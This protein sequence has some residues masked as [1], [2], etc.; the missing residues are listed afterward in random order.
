MKSKK[1][2]IAGGG[3]AG[4]RVAQDLVSAGF[5][6]VTLVDRK[7]YFEVTYATLR[8]LIEPETLGQRARMKFADFITAH[9]LQG[10]VSRL[11][12][13]AALVSGETIDFDYAV[14]AT[15]S[16]YK[17]LPLTKSHQATAL[18]DRHTEF[19]AWHR[20]LEAASDILILG[21][22]AVGVELAGE[23]AHAYPAQSVTLAEGTSTLLGELRPKAGSIAKEQLQKLGVTVLLDTMLQ[24]NDELL[25]RADLVYRCLGL[26][27]NTQLMEPYFSKNLDDNNRIKVD[28][29]LRVE[30]T[31]HIYAIGDCAN[32]PEGKMG[33]AADKQ[34]AAV[35]TNIIRFVNGKRP[36]PYKPSPMMALVPVG[37][38]MGLVQL[39]FCVTTFRPLVGMKQ[40]DLFIA[41]QFSNMGVN[42]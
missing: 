13:H 15:G 31:P 24:A 20:D 26:T 42:R 14:V 40:N 27:P 11:S 29:Y 9:F 38:E 7:D 34:G 30:G 39:P 32:V 3:F 28:Q 33:Y 21:G 6:N 1:I 41:K 12:E 35:A 22:G 8:G 37:P 4:A 5:S 18:E 19:D 17:T 23:I 10:E 2:L 36:K 25:V 16:R